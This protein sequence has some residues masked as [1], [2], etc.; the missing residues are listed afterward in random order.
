MQKPVKGVWIE[1]FLFTGGKADGDRGMIPIRHN[2]FSESPVLNWLANQLH[3][4][5]LSKQKS[6]YRHTHAGMGIKALKA[7]AQIVL[8]LFGVRGECALFVVD[9]QNHAVFFDLQF[10]PL[11]LKLRDVVHC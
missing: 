11:T 4:V 10:D 5:L 8:Y 3:T 9:A 1:E 2:S 7:A 6:L